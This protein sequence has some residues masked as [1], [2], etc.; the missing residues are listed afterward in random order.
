MGVGGGVLLAPNFCMAIQERNL[1][2]FARV[3]TP[4]TNPWG[5]DWGVL[6]G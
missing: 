1:S 4:V 5:W 6:I 2:G 3:F